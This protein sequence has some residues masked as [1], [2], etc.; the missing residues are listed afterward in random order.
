MIPQS[1]SNINNPTSTTEEKDAL[2]N[3][4]KENS[5]IIVETDENDP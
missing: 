2:G 5:I 1:L 4:K 3:F